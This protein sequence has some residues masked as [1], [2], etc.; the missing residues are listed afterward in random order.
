MHCRR[1]CARYCG[2][3]RRCHEMLLAERLVGEARL[4]RATRME[5]RERLVTALSAL[6]FLLAAIAIALGVPDERHVDPMLTLC[7]VG[8]FALIL[9]V[10]F[11]FGGYFGSPEQLA[12]VPLML[13]G[14]LPL[15][16]LLVAAAGLLA[17][18]PDFVRG[19]WHRE[20]WV[21]S[22]A[23]SWPCM[24]PVVVLALLAPGPLETGDLWIYGL[25]AAAQFGTDLSW[26]LV[27]N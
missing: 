15:V 23:D 22:F 16:P 25:A 27:R 7:L 10:R 1:R 13:L 6:T 24:G 4:R 26:G 14:P 19:T 21:N 20:R 3:R 12:I 5:T 11:E 2:I 8:G 17:L 9:Q 18:L